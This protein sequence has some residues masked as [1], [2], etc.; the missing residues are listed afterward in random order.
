MKLLR[1]GRA[2]P[3]CPEQLGGLP[4][5]RPP[6][7]FKAPGGGAGV[8]DSGAPML[9]ADG[10]D[11]AG[12]FLAGAREALGLA[13]LLGVEAAILKDGSPSCGVNYVRTCGGRTPGRGVFAELLARNSIEV[14]TVDSL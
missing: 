8:L 9:D 13:K 7:E 14:I 2:L 3:L 12:A 11:R 6:V 5:P 1:E 4:T 10:A